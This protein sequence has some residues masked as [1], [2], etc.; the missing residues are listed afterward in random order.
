MIYKANRAKLPADLTLPIYTSER[1]PI[2][3]RVKKEIPI[4]KNPY[5]IPSISANF[6]ENS[7][8]KPN[9]TAISANTQTANVTVAGLPFGR[10]FC[11]SRQP[12]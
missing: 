8:L 2:A 4:G 10:S 12:A 1:V 11:I 5:G 6:R 9:I 3:E 7:D